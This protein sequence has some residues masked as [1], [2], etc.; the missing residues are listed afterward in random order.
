MSNSA[1]T[2]TNKGMSGI[3]R[4]YVS[5]FTGLIWTLFLIGH[6]VGNLTLFSSDGTAFNKYAHFLESTGALLILAELSL[7]V[8][9]LMHAVS[10][11]QVWL[12]KRKARPEDY[13]LYKTAGAKS[14]QSLSSKTMIIS[15]SLIML[16]IVLHVAT[17]K[18]NLHLAASDIP[19]VVIP[20][21]EG[22]I[23]DLYQI[24][25]DTFKNPAAAFGYT[26]FMIFIGFHLR[27]GIWSALQ[28]L[29]AMKP[30][31]SPIIYTIAGL[32]AT[33]IAVGFLS[34]PLYIYF[35]TGM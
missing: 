28:S 13:K 32:L 20:G 11:I 18:F 19:K 16:F 9:I 30:K 35:T 6:L 1:N 27:H 14:K 34:I 33:L 21:I 25:R 24:V 2:K 29:G 12:G 10:G 17:F 7:I 8:F 3:I 23:R 26:F 15:G 31:L 5:G 22:E 4:K